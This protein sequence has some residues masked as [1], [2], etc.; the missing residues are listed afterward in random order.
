MI[1]SDRSRARESFEGFLNQDLVN[2]AAVDFRVISSRADDQ[3]PLRSVTRERCRIVSSN[4]REDL[5]VAFLPSRLESGRKQ[6]LR[7]PMTPVFEVDVRSESTNVIKRFGVRAKRLEHLESDES[8]V[9]SPQ[10]DLPHSPRWELDDV[11]A[12]GIDAMARRTRYG[13]APR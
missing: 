7:D 3:E 8:G 11:I 5:F 4:E 10:G 9:R 6:G 2:V 12:L 13:P 1:K